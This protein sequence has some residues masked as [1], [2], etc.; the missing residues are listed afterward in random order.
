MN[1]ANRGEDVTIR[2]ATRRLKP[3]RLPFSP[4]RLILSN[5]PGSEQSSEVAQ[6]EEETQSILCL[7]DNYTSTNLSPRP[8]HGLSIEF[9]AHFF[10][11]WFEA[12]TSYYSSS[13]FS[14]LFPHVVAFAH[15]LSA[16]DENAVFDPGGLQRSLKAGRE[17]IYSFLQA[18]EKGI[19]RSVSCVYFYF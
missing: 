6:R 13:Y 11:K 8:L 9:A 16:E 1:S 3:T 2:V 17:V 5:L 19:V 10:L 12:C 14:Q 15:Y 4:R 7:V 18:G